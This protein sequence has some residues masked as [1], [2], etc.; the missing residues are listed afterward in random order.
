MGTTT[1]HTPKPPGGPKRAA[2]PTIS[3]SATKIRNPL[4]QSQAALKKQ[5]IPESEKKQSE[6]RDEL[7]AVL[8]EL[9]AV[10]E[11]TGKVVQS[12]ETRINDGQKFVDDP[13]PQW[14]EQ[15]ADTTVQL[16]IA[17]PLDIPEFNG[18]RVQ[19]VL[20]K[21]RDKEQP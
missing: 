13:L 20:L 7:L 5:K 21:V 2:R 14:I 4:D 8:D 18:D 9:L 15:I 11:A 3:T 12:I 1:Y 17:L 10:L 6:V 19:L 16:E